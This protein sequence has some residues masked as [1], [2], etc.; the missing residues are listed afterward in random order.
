MRAD[1][2]ELVRAVPEPELFEHGIIQRGAGAGT[3]SL[4]LLNV[5]G[6]L[7][8]FLICRMEM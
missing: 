8:C 7:S 5:R 2:L 3:Q 4:G 6:F 1:S